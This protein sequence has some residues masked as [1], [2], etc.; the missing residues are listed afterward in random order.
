MSSYKI[1]HGL[2]GNKWDAGLTVITTYRTGKFISDFYRNFLQSVKKSCW[3]VGGG[4]T[5]WNFWE[6]LSLD[7]GFAD[8]CPIYC[9]SSSHNDTIVLLYF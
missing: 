1:K 2:Q 5:R 6:D 3:W 4:R 9:I 8:L 7:V